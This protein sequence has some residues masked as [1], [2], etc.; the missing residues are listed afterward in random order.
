M[1]MHGAIERWVRVR[2]S[3]ADVKGS[4]HRMGMGME[5]DGVGWVTTLGRVRDGGVPSLFVG[6][7]SD[8]LHDSLFGRLTGARAGRE[9][10]VGRNLKLRQQVGGSPFAVASTRSFALTADI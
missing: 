1:A 4:R 8:V 5:N 10:G 6:F 7:S 3:A 9:E 2:I